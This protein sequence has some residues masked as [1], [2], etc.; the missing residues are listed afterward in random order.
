MGVTFVLGGWGGA[1]GEYQVVI[2]S[3]MIESKKDVI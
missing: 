3:K 1:G 2:K